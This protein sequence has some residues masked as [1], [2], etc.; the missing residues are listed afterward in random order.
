MEWILH[1]P[2][3]LAFMKILAFF[4]NIAVAVGVALYPIIVCAFRFV[5]IVGPKKDSAIRTEVKTDLQ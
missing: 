4:R 2:N 5:N 1:L 3:W